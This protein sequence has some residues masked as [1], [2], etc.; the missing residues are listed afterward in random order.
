MKRVLTFIARMRPPHTSSHTF[1]T[2]VPNIAS[3][4]KSCV[5]G[6]P[7]INWSVMPSVD[8]IGKPKRKAAAAA[9]PNVQTAPNLSLWYR[10]PYDHRTVRRHL[11]VTTTT[12]W[13]TF[14]WILFFQGRP[15]RTPQYIARMWI[16]CGSIQSI[17]IVCSIA[18]HLSVSGSISH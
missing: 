16:R 4:P 9:S 1:D 12:Y 2:E 15:W 8:H 13:F 18:I 14:D 7:S 6:V 3:V 17:I 11:S 10:I 5:I